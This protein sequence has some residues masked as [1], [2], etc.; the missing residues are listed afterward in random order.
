MTVQIQKPSSSAK[1]LF[2]ALKEDSFIRRV[3]IL[4]AL[5]V[6]ALAAVGVTAFFWLP[7]I[8]TAVIFGISTFILGDAFLVEYRVFSNTYRREE[9][10][11]IANQ[12]HAARQLI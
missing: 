2:T 11:V 1:V 6:V 7:I 10:R 12:K 3:F 9:G 8:V 5:S 4:S